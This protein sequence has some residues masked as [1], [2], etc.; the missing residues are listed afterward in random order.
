[1]SETCVE[2]RGEEQLVQAGTSPGA[3]RPISS[4]GTHLQQ[5]Q[6][7]PACLPDEQ[8]STRKE[9]SEEMGKGNELGEEIQE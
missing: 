9:G 1:M 2:V 8:T 4:Q 6:G 7:D 5:S 3:H